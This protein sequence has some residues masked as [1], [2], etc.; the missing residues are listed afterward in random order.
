MNSSPSQARGALVRTP[1]EVGETV[2]VHYYPHAGTEWLC[3]TGE[4]TSMHQKSMGYPVAS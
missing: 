3:A 2:W 4:V 1:L